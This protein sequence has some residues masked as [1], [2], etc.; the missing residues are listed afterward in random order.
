MEH[1]EKKT[2]SPSQPDVVGVGMQ[3]GA[4]KGECFFINLDVCH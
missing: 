4:N 2:Q 1:Q 3:E